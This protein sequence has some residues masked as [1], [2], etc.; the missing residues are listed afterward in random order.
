MR[1]VTGLGVFFKANNPDLLHEWYEK[2]LAI[3][4][5]NCFYSAAQALFSDAMRGP[6]IL[7]DLEST[8][9]KPMALA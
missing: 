1:R 6:A 7:S 2:H 5:E 8:A 3:K 9:L 4:R